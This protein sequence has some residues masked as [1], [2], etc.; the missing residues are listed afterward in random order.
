MDI[1]FFYFVTIHAFDRQTDR[2]PIARP[3][4]HSMHAVI[5]YYSLSR[6]INMAHRIHTYKNT[7]TNQPQL[8]TDT[9]KH[10][11]AEVKHKHL[12]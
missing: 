4:L 12:H 3:R 6:A 1:C 7:N 8:L 10:R 2:I 11:Q 5:S 9:I